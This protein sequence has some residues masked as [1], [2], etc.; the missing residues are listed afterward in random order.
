MKRIDFNSWELMVPGSY[1]IDEK[2]KILAYRKDDP[3]DRWYLP[4]T[5]ESYVIGSIRCGV[6]G[7]LI[8]PDSFSTNI[9]QGSHMII[10]SPRGVNILLG[11]IRKVEDNYTPDKNLERL[12]NLWK[13][14][15]ILT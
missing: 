12:L 2:G 1:A 11:E 4:S 5:K 9:V 13:E 14:A 3:R 8:I 10:A 15:G 7:P 6:V